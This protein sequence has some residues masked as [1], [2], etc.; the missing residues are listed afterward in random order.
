MDVL[1]NIGGKCATLGAKPVHISGHLPRVSS[2][3]Q[4]E[5]LEGQM[6][7]LKDYAASRG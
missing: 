4:K 6:Q 3:D 1:C 7:R 5:D 2:A